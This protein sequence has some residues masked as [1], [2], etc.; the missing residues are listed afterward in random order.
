MF[1]GCAGAGPALNAERSHIDSERAQR[2][3]LAPDK[4]VGWSIIIAHKIGD[5]RH[6]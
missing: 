4:G 1:R 2:R 3:Y 6:L 5:A